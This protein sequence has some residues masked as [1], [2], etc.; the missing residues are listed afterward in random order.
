MEGKGS[1]EQAK[2][3]ETHKF[4]LSGVLQKHQ[5]NNHH[6]CME[7]LA[8]IHIGSMI[9]TSVTMR[10]NEQYLIDSVG[11]VLLAFSTHFS[12]RILP[13]TLLWGS[14]SSA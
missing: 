9:V 13:R 5:T 11:L 7:D 1:Q 12:L 4:P 3:S 14:L 8:Q 2:E 10:P 6:I